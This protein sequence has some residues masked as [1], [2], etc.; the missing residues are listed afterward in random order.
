MESKGRRALR[1][2]APGTIPAE[3]V[4]P[5][6]T[7]PDEATPAE[8]LIPPEVPVD[9]AVP[10]ATVAA[11]PRVDTLAAAAKNASGA[12]VFD[13]GREVFAAL[14]Q[15]QTAAARGLE[16][17]SV[18]VTGLAISGIDAATRTATDMLGVKTL[19]DAIEVNAGFTRSSFDA[20]VGSSA[21]LSELGMKLAT[22]ASQPILTQLGKS[23]IK[24]VRLA[25]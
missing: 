23:W 13:F 1:A 12:E 25:F 6:A 20:L 16:A 10:V 9:V 14:V 11:L 5:S 22:E 15:S 8:E 24:A 17:L 18:E 19:S 2:A 4:N 21:K 3:T 7:A